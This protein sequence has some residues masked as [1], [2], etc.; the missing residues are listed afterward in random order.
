MV[1]AAALFLTL[2][3]R[4]GSG[5][6]PVAIYW[7]KL[8]SLIVCYRVLDISFSLLAAAAGEVTSYLSW[9]E[10]NFSVLDC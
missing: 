9:L 1:I 5:V 3:L 6:P 8:D 7:K 10:L 2:E 4:Y